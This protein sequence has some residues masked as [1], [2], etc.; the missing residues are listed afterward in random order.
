MNVIDF[1]CSNR[2]TKKP[3][4]DENYMMP[5]THVSELNSTFTS[6][7]QNINNT[8]SELNSV[9]TSDDQNINSRAALN[10]TIG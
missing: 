1:C 4:S 9:S 6:D 5:P 8:E 3:E 7:D 10:S 2:P